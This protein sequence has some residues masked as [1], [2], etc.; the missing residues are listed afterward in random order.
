MLAFI[1]KKDKVGPGLAS[2]FTPK[3]RTFSFP[4]VRDSTGTLTQNPKCIMT[5]DLYKSRETP[6]PLNLTDYLDE[7]P[8]PKLKQDHSKMLDTPITELEV[9]GVIKNLKRGSAPG[10]D[11]FSTCH[12]KTFA[13][14]KFYNA[15]QGSSTLDS[16]ANLAYVS[17]M[18]KSGKDSSEVGNYRPISLIIDLKILTKI[19]AN[20][21]SEFIGGYIH[22]DQVGFIPGRQ[23]PD[24]IRRAVDV[25]YLLIWK[26]DGGPNQEGFLLSVNL[27]NA[28]DT[29]DWPYL[30]EVLRGWGFGPLLIEPLRNL[31]S[32]SST[33]VKR[34]LDTQEVIDKDALFLLLFS[35]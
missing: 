33:Q 16:S 29:V 8:L 26:W 22:K 9:L 28:F 7:I 21:L 32:N 27:Q 34:F 10:P 30:F 6:R 35:P 12:Y 19:M 2:K 31:Y 1:F 20:R 23:G 17:V 5:A 13:S 11:G 15:F 24:Q 25:I 14:I 4:K 3:P 18:P